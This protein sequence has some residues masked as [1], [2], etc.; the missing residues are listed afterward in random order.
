MKFKDE[1]GEEYRAKARRYPHTN[2]VS[3][4]KE[5]LSL[6]TK[7]NPETGCIEWL[8]HTT[9]K[10]TRGYGSM[11]FRKKAWKVH[12]IAWVLRYGEIPDGLSVLHKCDNRRCCNP[13]HLFLGTNR[14]NVHD[15]ISKGRDRH[16]Q[17]SLHWAAKLNEEAVLE[18]RKISDAEWKSKRLT[19]V[20]AAKFNCTHEAIMYARN[21]KTFRHLEEWVE[22]TKSRGEK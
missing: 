12:R 10:G 4:A 19:K 21:G 18:I 15:M 1:N 14:D 11:N 6:H 7:S 5:K 16:L 8:L 22:G 2:S 13:E 17:G 3:L 9:P 20:Y